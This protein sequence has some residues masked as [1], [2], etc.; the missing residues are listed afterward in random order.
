MPKN[1]GFE[2]TYRKREDMALAGIAKGLPLVAL[3]YRDGVVLAT[4]NTS[5]TL[6]KIREVHDFIALGAAGAKY[7]EI[8]IAQAYLEEVIGRIEGVFG[9]KDVDARYLAEMLMNH[10]HAQFVDQRLK[11]YEIGIIIAEAAEN[12]TH[13]LYR[14]EPNGAIEES[15]M[16]FS[17]AD[18][19]S[20]EAMER[21]LENEWQKSLNLD[22]AIALAKR[23]VTEV[24]IAVPGRCFWEIGVI[25]ITQAGEIKFRR[26][27]EEANDAPKARKANETGRE[28]SRTSSASQA[29]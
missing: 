3:V 18:P 22:E 28:K 4:R 10:V 8:N 23:A 6:N 7:P 1:S 17:L 12:G 19:E 13:V 15:G 2:E 29:D 24:R 27:G 21:V 20:Q 11:P 26:Y 9:P 25:D 14:I 16:F 5:T